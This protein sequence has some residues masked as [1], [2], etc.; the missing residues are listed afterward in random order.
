MNAYATR[1]AAAGL[2]E[3]RAHLH[4][5]LRKYATQPEPAAAQAA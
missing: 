3:R 5:S 4:P 1:L 2:P